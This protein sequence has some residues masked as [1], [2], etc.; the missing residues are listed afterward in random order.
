[1][2]NVEPSVRKYLSPTFLTHIFV[3][4]KTN[5]KSVAGVLPTADNYVRLLLV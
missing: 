5:K 1:M 2:L 4:I 3:N